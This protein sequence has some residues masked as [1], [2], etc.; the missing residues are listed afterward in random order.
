M[1]NTA[2][3][4]IELL[5]EDYS[6]EN[7]EIASKFLYGDAIKHEKYPPTLIEDGSD[8]IYNW[9]KKFNLRVDSSIKK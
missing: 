6:D 4:I 8:S 2:E 7:R 3:Y 9:K 5:L 1:E